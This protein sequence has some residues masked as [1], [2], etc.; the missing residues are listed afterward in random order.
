MK[1]KNPWKK[2]LTN[3]YGSKQRHINSN[4][5]GEKRRIYDYEDITWHDLE[6]I[7]LR[8]DQ[9]SYWLN[10]P[11]NP[12]DVFT[13]YNNLAPSVDRIDGNRGYFLDN[14]C[15]CTRFEN[16]GFCDVDI[17]KRLEIMKFMKDNY[18]IFREIDINKVKNNHKIVGSLE[19]FCK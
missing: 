15:I 6:H 2:L 7:F 5:K 19:G 14:I 1:R 4:L 9:R 18:H 12:Y 3:M 17:H 10:I 8:Q 13:S 11:I 16:Y